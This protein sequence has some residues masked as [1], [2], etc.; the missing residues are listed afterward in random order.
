MGIS[1][2]SFGKTKEGAEVTLYTITNKNGFRVGALD[3][4]AVIVKNDGK[5]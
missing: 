2:K 4:G 5:I 1:T 3:Y